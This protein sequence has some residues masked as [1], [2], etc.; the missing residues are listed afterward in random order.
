MEQFHV[1]DVDVIV[2]C[3]RLY[4]KHNVIQEKAFRTL[5]NLCLSDTD[6]L[7]ALQ[8]TGG[9]VVMSAALVLHWEN[10][11]VKTEAYSTLS[12]LFGKLAMVQPHM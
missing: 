12:L 8:D 11:A 4:S 6:R 7:L 2:N 1:E 10:P 3:M 9:F 5:A